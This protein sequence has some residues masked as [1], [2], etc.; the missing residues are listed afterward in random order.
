[1]SAMGVSD[2]GRRF[3]VVVHDVAPAFL[4]QLARITEALVPRVGRKVAGAV[5]PC[6]HGSPIDGP[7]GGFER[8]VVSSFG[9]VL[10]HGYTHR[11]DRPGVLS[12]FTGR[13]DELVGLPREEVCRRLGLGRELLQCALGIA[14]A[15][16]VAPAWQFGRMTAGDLGRCGFRYVATFGAILAAS[17]PTIPLCTWSWDWGVLGLLGRVG[18]RFGDVYWRIRPA[19]LPCVV[20]HPADVERGYLPRVL[21]VV[22]RLLGLGRTPG[23]LSEFLP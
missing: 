23:L 2:V 18:Q 13:S 14:P 7:G 16:F 22:D 19:T 5:V 10:Q 12:L 20:V 3:A 11:Q 8:F 6:W 1:M 17:G 4:P 21:E 9:E 15:G